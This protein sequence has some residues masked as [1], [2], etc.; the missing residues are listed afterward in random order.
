MVSELAIKFIDTDLMLYII[1]Q[2]CDEHGH[3]IPP[4]DWT[5]YNSCT[6]FKFLFHHNQ[7]SGGN[8]DALFNIWLATFNAHH[9]EPPFHNHKELYDTIDST[10]LGDVP[11]ESFK[12]KFEV[13]VDGC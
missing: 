4:D 3:F 7:M 6:E 11:W 10:P 13:S 1:G 9:D 5:P 8:I 12:V 2:I